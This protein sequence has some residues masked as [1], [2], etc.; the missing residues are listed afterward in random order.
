M[1]SIEMTVRG[2]HCDL[3]A[4][5]NNARYLEFLEE[6]RWDWINHTSL[7]KFIQERGLSFIVVSITI[8]YRYPAILNNIL[9]ISVE[10]GPIGNSSARVRQV[11][12]R[13]EDGKIIADAEVTF[14][15]IDNST[16]KP[17]A[18]D[19]ELKNLFLK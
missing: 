4:H 7:M 15:L 5:V 13:K 10:P 3:Y 19:E 17:T 6:A 11:V 12:S 1:H 16:G 18:I 8:N 14:A 9:N 2:F